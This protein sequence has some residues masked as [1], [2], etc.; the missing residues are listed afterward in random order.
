MEK[1]W[2]KAITISH[3]KIHCMSKEK[4][5]NVLIKPSYAKS[6]NDTELFLF[7]P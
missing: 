6:I 1:I 5:L 3:I 7:K 4:V 2:L